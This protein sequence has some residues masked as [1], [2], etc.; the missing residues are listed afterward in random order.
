VDAYKNGNVVIHNSNDDNYKKED[1]LLENHYSQKEDKKNYKDYPSMF[2][3]VKCAYGDCNKEF[4]NSNTYADDLSTGVGYS[5]NKDNPNVDV[6]G[7]RKYLED[8]N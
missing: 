1:K 5:K 4:Y 6:T 3:T 2:D 8:N 7:S